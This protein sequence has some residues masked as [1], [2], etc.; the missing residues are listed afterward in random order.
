MWADVW[1]YLSQ[2]VSVVHAMDQNSTDSA[3][4]TQSTQEEETLE[5]QDFIPCRGYVTATLLL[6]ESLSV[7]RPVGCMHAGVDRSGFPPG[8]MR[9]RTMQMPRLRVLSGNSLGRN[10]CLLLINIFA[11]VQEGQVAS[12]SSSFHQ[13]GRYAGQ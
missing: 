7:L 5:N 3:K 9:W 4:C 12:S 1:D 13:F 10:G 11:R 8:T 2:G 6:V